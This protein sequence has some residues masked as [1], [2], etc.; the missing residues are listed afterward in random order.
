M[1][2]GTA[3]TRHPAG[4]RGAR[5]GAATIQERWDEVKG[6]PSGFD[7]MR[8]SLAVSVLLW[9]SYQLS[10]GSPAAYRILSGPAGLLLQ[11]ILPMF[12]ALSGFLV[13]GSLERNRDLKTFL[14]LR[15]I[16]IYPALCVEVFISALVLGPLVTT[17][18]IGAYFSSRSFYSY[19]MN[20]VGWVHY[21]L[22]GVFLSNPEPGR[23]NTS[24]WTVPFELECYLLI[25]VLFLVGYMRSRLVSS[26]MFLGCT[27]LV[28]ALVVDVHQPGV[29]LSSPGRVL[30]LC[31]LAG[32]LLFRARALV[33]FGAFHALAALGLSIVLLRYQYTIV[34]AALPVAYATVYA[35]LL[36]P[37]RTFIVDRGDYSYGIYLYAAPIQQTVSWL[38]GASVTWASN[39][40]LA[41]PVTI[42]FAVFSWHCI[43]KPFL[44]VKSYVV[45]SSRR[46]QGQDAVAPAL[47]LRSAPA[48][49]HEDPGA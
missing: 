1:G 48:G 18:R 11:L 17:S 12:F 34:F 19:M 27:A 45:G 36:N 41:L 8:V 26:A 42:L 37:E 29:I 49:F 46:P 44:R 28:L 6:R 21:N 22:P 13:S 23:V 47:P 2:T 35:G 39:A 31:F 20:S 38:L 14:A 30:V 33:P 10:Y 15:V 9:H 25:A 32:S 7:Y 43:E 24:I 40:A 16:R 4:S 5:Q 3:H